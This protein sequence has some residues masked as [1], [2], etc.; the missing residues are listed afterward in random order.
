MTTFKVGQRV[1]FIDS[2]SR[3][4]NDTELLITSIS[5]D[6]CHLRLDGERSGYHKSGFEHAVGTY[7]NEETGRREH[8]V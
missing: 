6:G 2:H 7:I 4:K 1:L 3:Y 8:Y 5:P